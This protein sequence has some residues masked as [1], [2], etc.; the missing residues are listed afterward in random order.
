M[1]PEL[2]SRTGPVREWLTELTGVDRVWINAAAEAT[3]RILEQSPTSIFWNPA[4]TAYQKDP[5][6]GLAQAALPTVAEPAAEALANYNFFRQEAIERESSFDGLTELKNAQ[7]FGFM[8]NMVAR[9]TGWSPAKAAHLMRSYLPGMRGMLFSDIPNVVAGEPS[10]PTDY[11]A[12]AGVG[13][14]GALGFDRVGKSWDPW[15]PQS[16][17]VKTFMDF[18]ER[19][20]ELQNQARILKNTAGGEQKLMEL[21]ATQPLLAIADTIDDL[22]SHQ[23]ALREWRNAIM[24]DRS[25]TIEAQNIMLNYGGEGDKG[26]GPDRLMTLHAI[27]SNRVILEILSDWENM[28]AGGE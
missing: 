28:K 4:K 10:D 15:G 23:K 3:D 25:L 7:R 2:T 24:A 27:E 1:A 17:H 9:A 21:Q 26:M 6:L 16:E 8:Q 19:S 18:R 22:S 20:R 11:R 13:V 12:A 14:M 5:L